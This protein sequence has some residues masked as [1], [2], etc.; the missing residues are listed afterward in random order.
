MTIFTTFPHCSSCKMLELGSCPPHKA[1]ALG[2]TCSAVLPNGAARVVAKLLE[3][4]SS[5]YT[6]HVLL[7]LKL[8][9]SNSDFRLYV[10]FYTSEKD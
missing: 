1:F 6:E 8:E 10:F 4:S 3:A 9:T 5:S 7:F 2:I